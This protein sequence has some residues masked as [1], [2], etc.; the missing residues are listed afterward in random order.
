MDKTAIIVCSYNMPERTDALCEH[1]LKTVKVPHTLYVIDNGSD[2][3]EPSLYT[4]HWLP[5][6]LQT[7]G[8]FRRG[9]EFADKFDYKYYWLLI[10]SAAFIETDTRDPLECLLPIMEQDEMAYA[11][12]PSIKFGK[13]E[14]AWSKWLEPRKHSTFRRIWGVDYISTLF[15][16]EFLNKIGRF[17]KELPMMWG[18]IGECNYKARKRG[19]HIYVC[20]NYTM[21]KETDIGY[22][23]DRMNMTSVDRK[24]IAAAE[25]DRVLTPI[26]GSNYREKFRYENT[27]MGMDGEY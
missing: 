7:G 26:Y 23:M 21:R 6:N 12:Q 5:D 15:R 10:T 3:V 4:T 13:K 18:A 22:K 20:D 14:E 11:V 2:L 9:L 1:I 24:R 17:R 25:S 27:E 19:W 16:A 8:G